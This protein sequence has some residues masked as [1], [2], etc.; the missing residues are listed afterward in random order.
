[1]SRLTFPPTR[2]ETIA[3]DDSNWQTVKNEYDTMYGIVIKTTVDTYLPLG[4]KCDAQVEIVGMINEFDGKYAEAFAR[5]LIDLIN[6]Y[7]AASD[8]NVGCDDVML[9]LVESRK[10]TGVYD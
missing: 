4:D 9:S 7:Q 8:C 3:K 6:C 2:T 10:E 1:M 5:D